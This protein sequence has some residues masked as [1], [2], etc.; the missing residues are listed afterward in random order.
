[1][2]SL[3]RK[4]KVLGEAQQSLQ[5]DIVENVALGVRVEAR[6]QQLCQPKQLEKFRTFV[7]DLDRVLSLLLSL[8]GRLARVDNALNSLEDDPA[9]KERQTLLEKK[10]LLLQQHKDAE[11]LK[12]SV[13]RR[14]CLVYD[15]LSFQ[16]TND[17][18]DDFTHFVKMKSS[19]IVEQRNLEDKIK[20]GEEQLA[21]LMDSLQPKHSRS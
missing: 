2:R 13:E 17:D 18:L 6:V 20:L 16:L 12:E 21:C 7:G 14:Q 19:L 1:M 11:E 15:I 9:A 5:E 10:Q 3:S 4:L 8:L